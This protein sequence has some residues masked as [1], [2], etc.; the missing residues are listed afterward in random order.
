MLAQRGTAK[1]STDQSRSSA[2]IVSVAV[3]QRIELFSIIFRLAGADEYRWEPRTPYT[4]AV[5]AHFARFAGHRAVAL[6]RRL[7]SERGVSYNAVPDLAVLVGPLPALA[8]RVPVE[9]AVDLD[10]R[11]KAASAREFI[12]LARDFAQVSNAATFF[13]EHQSTYATLQ[14]RMRDLIES[15]TELDWI[16]TFYGGDISDRFIVAPSILAGGGNYGPRVRL[17]DGTREIYAVLGTG[18]ADEDGSPVVSVNHASLL[19]HEFGHSFVNPVVYKHIAELEHVGIA[20]LETTRSAMHRQGYT[21]PASVLHETLIRAG[22]AR[23]KLARSGKSVAERELERQR[24]LGF[25]WIDDVYG[26]LAEYEANRSNYA[27]F[28][29]F[30]PRLK[31]QL[32]EL[33]QRLPGIA[34]K[35]APVVE[36]SSPAASASNV[37]PKLTEVRITFDRP[38][39]E[40]WG[41]DSNAFGSAL[42]D[43]TGIKLAN[44]GKTLVIGVKLKPKSR[45]N[46]VFF[47]SGDPALR[48]AEGVLLGSYSLQFK[49]GAAV[50]VTSSRKGKSS[51]S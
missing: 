11:W 6:A 34:A 37:D 48:S 45:Y 1:R 46:L 32:Q 25:I 51:R 4:D 27:D 28:A 14:R 29:A 10:P 43:I 18:M 20:M 8:E 49:T 21:D 3:D 39:A 16:R 44:D 30:Y 35:F 17:S 33:A 9:S 41:L 19:V 36:S 38:I 23:Y 13:E 7:R 24:R 26:Y 5:D 15:E 40:R 2:S 47:S 12:A 22:V 50:S 42:P 31:V